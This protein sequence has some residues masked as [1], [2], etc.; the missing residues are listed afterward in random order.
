ME[1]FYGFST[2]NPEELK[3]QGRF[4]DRFGDIKSMSV[5]Q[6]LKR[7]IDTLSNIQL[8][9]VSIYGAIGEKNAQSIISSKNKWDYVFNRIIPHPR[10]KNAFLE[11]DAVIY[12][13]GNVFCVEIKRYKGKIY[14]SKR[15]NEKGIFIGNDRSRIV[16]EKEGNHGEGIFYKEF[17]NPLNKT[18]Y[19]IYNLK[20]YLSKIDNRFSRLC[21]NPIVGFSDK[22]SD[23]SAIRSIKDGIGYISEIPKVVKYHRN[24]KFAHYPFNWIID[25]LKKLPT[26]DFVLTR[27]DERINGIIMDNEFKCKTT[28][29]RPYV[30]PYKEIYSISVERK[31]RL[32]AHD[33]ITVMKTNNEKDIFSCVNGQIKLDRFG[34]YQVHK[35]R[36]IKKIEIGTGILRYSAL[37]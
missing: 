31:G 1:S 3:I 10:K 26:W 21:I 8:D 5:W 27:K 32:S 19:F 30:I 17:P 6:R 24:E 25:G 20:Q 14:F 33:D 13:D 36:N 15:C 23:I 34:K 35:L 29:G 4:P 22:E 11:I 18:K 7:V 16:I 37:K 12:A 2:V 9:D 28:D